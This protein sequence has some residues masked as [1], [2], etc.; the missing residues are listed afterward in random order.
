MKQTIVINPFT[1]K[2]IFCRKKEKDC[3]RK[4]YREK[5]LK[6]FF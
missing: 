3:F 1:A 6:Y 2:L 5:N 4:F